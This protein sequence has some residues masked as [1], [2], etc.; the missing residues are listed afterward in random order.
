MYVLL[1]SKEKQ[2]VSIT[3]MFYRLRG[4]IQVVTPNREKVRHFAHFLHLRKLPIPARVCTCVWVYSWG[5]YFIKTRH[6]LWNGLPRQRISGVLPAEAQESSPRKSRQIVCSSHDIRGWSLAISDIDCHFLNFS[7]YFRV[8]NFCFYW[9]YIT[10]ITYCAIY[11]RHY[12]GKL[13]NEP[14]TLDNYTFAVTFA[15]S[16][17]TTCWRNSREA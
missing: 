1:L 4:A 5:F 16:L 17:I 14:S 8:I 3:W 12:I 2:H 7:R 11:S 15:I 6:R 10:C 9:L 13:R